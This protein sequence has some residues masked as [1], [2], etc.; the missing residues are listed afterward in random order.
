[1]RSG[2]SL[3]ELLLA[4]VLSS[5]LLLG[6]CET[7]AIAARGARMQNAYAQLQDNYRFLI[8]W[9]TNQL[10][11]AGD[12]SCQFDLAKR[13]SITPV[14]GYVKSQLPNGFNKNGLSNTDAFVLQSCVELKNSTH[15]LKQAMYLASDDTA[16]A[17]AS[18][19]GLFQEIQGSR[20]E[21]MVRGLNAW[22][23]RYGYLNKSN[24]LTYLPAT[25]IAD[26]SHLKSIS[27]SF[28]LCTTFPVFKQATL[29]Q[30]ADLKFFAADH[31]LCRPGH[32]YVVLR[33]QS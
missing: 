6:L 9:L 17:V 22:S 13:Q 23:I 29:Y 33:A 21:L 16:D 12:Q 7:Y 25:A 4:C 11:N 14:Q 27:I 20:R 19:N 32:L 31:Q 3:F 24:Q 2:F 18:T 10:R 8:F 28:I 1:M 15:F 26:W 5:I 30:F